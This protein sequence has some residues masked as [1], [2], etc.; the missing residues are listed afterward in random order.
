MRKDLIVAASVLFFA[1]GDQAVAEYTCNV[2]SISLYSSFS[3][4]TRKFTGSGNTEAQAR[5]NGIANCTK[6]AAV[7]CYIVQC[8]GK[9]K[10]DACSV[11]DQKLMSGISNAARSSAMSKQH[12]I[13]AIAAY[14]TC[15][16]KNGCPSTNN[17]L[18]NQAKSCLGMDD[19]GAGQ[20]LNYAVEHH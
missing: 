14:Q 5:A 20:C 12:A 18:L 3:L 4:A 6:A 10:Q 9:D 1:A 8:I 19:L 16:A 15:I 17:T 11:C 7:G 2:D 13:A